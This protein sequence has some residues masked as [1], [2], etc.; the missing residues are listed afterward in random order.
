MNSTPKPARTL[1]RTGQWLGFLARMSGQGYQAIDE[2]TPRAETDEVAMTCRSHPE[3]KVEVW[4]RAKFGQWL[5]TFVPSNS[6]HFA[7]PCPECAKD[8]EAANVRKHEANRA[9]ER[10]RVDARLAVFNH[11]L[12]TYRPVTVKD[13]TTG[14]VKAQ[15]NDIQCLS[16]EHVRP[17]FLHATLKTAEAR[18]KMGCPNCKPLPMGPRPKA[19]KAEMA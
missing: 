12:V 18:H 5:A 15:T 10:L 11:R 16:C 2:Q 9:A 4:T 6:K 17:V 13:P 19:E 7:P 8:Y 3:A 14:K 1:G